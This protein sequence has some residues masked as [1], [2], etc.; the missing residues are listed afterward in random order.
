MTIFSLLYQTFFFVHWV[1]YN[2]SR[3]Q[4][5]RSHVAISTVI[6]FVQWHSV[7]NHVYRK[8]PGRWT[9]IHW[10]CV[11]YLTYCL[12]KQKVTNTKVLQLLPHLN[13]YYKADIFQTGLQSGNNTCKTPKPD[14]HLSNRLKTRTQLVSGVFQA[15]YNVG[16]IDSLVGII[17]GYDCTGKTHSSFTYTHTHTHTWRPWRTFSLAPP[18]PLP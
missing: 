13:V 12:T 8:L 14:S 3:K 9:G 18:H 11:L 4:T 6:H 16:I 15:R 1:N 7:T 5:F 2:Y 17:C 10:C